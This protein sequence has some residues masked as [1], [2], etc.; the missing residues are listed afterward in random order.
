MITDSLEP[1]RWGGTPG[2]GS[3]AT[4]TR[5][6]SLNP[7]RSWPRSCRSMGTSVCDIPLKSP[8]RVGR[9]VNFFMRRYR[10]GRL[11]VSALTLSTCRYLRLLCRLARR[12]KGSRYWCSSC[13]PRKIPQR[14]QGSFRQSPR[15]WAQGNLFNIYASFPAELTHVSQRSDVRS[16]Y[17]AV[18][19]GMR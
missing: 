5:N 3:D 14:D 9:F 1:H 7:P 12:F 18:R 16:V 11:S 13:R 19:E 8:A 6:S 2:T 15:S 4:S 10:N 17:T